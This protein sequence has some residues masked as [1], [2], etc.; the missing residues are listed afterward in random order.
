MEYKYIYRYV[1]VY[2][3]VFIGVQKKIFQKYF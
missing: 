3:Y 2:I 1:N